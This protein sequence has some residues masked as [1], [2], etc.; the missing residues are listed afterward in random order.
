[1][2]RTPGFHP[3]NRGSIPLGDGRAGS[4]ESA[5]FLAFSV[6]RS[7]GGERM[8]NIENTHIIKKLDP[9]T[10][11]S[12]IATGGPLEQLFSSFEERPTQIELLEQ[13][14]KTFNEDK[15]GAFEAG[16]G[17]GKS[18]AY[19]IPA[20][21]WALDNKE[22]VVISTGTI[23][24]QQQLYEKDI[25]LACRVLNC[26][27]KAVLIKGRQNYVCLR[28]LND[29]MN[30]K[31]LFSDEDDE[32]QTII[33]W[34]STT[35]TG[36]NSD[37]SFLPNSSLWQ[38]INSESDACM[39]QRC[40]F[41]GQCFVM[42]V[43]KQAADAHILIV[44][45]H[46]LFADIE[47]RFG[48]GF[49][50]TAVLP[51]YKRLIFD[52]AHGIEDAATS[53][54]SESLT[55]FSFTKQLN[56][57]YRTHKSAVSGHLYTLELLSSR[58]DS[59]QDAIEE[60][61]KIKEHIQKAEQEALKLLDSGFTWRLKE[62]TAPR[63]S[64][65]F[66]VMQTLRS[67]VVR[68]CAAIR[69]LIDGIDDDTL[70]SP[71]VWETKQILRRLE[72]IGLMCK[73]YGEWVERP[74]TIFWLEK[75]GGQKKD[76]YPRFYQTPLD[77]ASL[78]NTGVFEPLKTVIC[79]SATL[80][81]AGSFDFWMKRC[82]LKDVD[83]ERILCEQFASPF[84]YA[85]NLVFSIPTDIPLPHEN[86]FQQYIEQAIVK[87]IEAS[88]GRSL[89]LFTSYDSL[90]SAC[91]Y[92][93]HML[94][95]S[96]IQVFKQ[97]DDDRFRLLESFK[98]DVTSVLFATDSFW[99]GVDVPGESLSQVILV[100]L[101][102]SVPTDPVFAARSEAIEKNGGSSFME[103][104]LP[105]AVIKFRQG[106]GRLIR[107]SEDRGAVTALDKRLIEKRYGQLFLESI[108]QT[109][110]LFEPLA[111]ICSSLTRFIDS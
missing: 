55:R 107:H 11:S 10:T 4:S 103:L 63:A 99:E 36:S 38:R 100:K 62:D 71:P 13:I 28:R 75:S 102:F 95:S 81:T 82:G 30:E 72:A 12:F 26:D 18:F 87:L 19:L 5:F 32:L 69:D 93:R 98:T 8:E 22:R 73:N 21:L 41:F 90:R 106:F 60:I 79:V 58:P 74:D 65:F 27:I 16:T 25:P 53:F 67:D 57:L 78:M 1:M 44:N 51:P 61:Q 39:G 94:A 43:R 14:C 92:A 49:D 2:V 45:H 29:A 24:L 111:T 50:D 89:V 88:E 35:E 76:V 96:N 9:Q 85:K 109:K 31:D 42:K 84:N 77:I 80:T 66:I 7:Q 3:G 52:E 97:G 105:G 6:I 47:M 86:S 54:F 83:Q 104:S 101:P 46:L 68:L 37:L 108:P 17:V 34:T 48:M 40:R 91:D 15:I 64:D 59:A 56:R 20:M 33:K 70:D 23:N 110:R